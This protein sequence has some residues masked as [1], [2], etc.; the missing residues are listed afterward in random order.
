MKLEIIKK[1]DCYKGFLRFTSIA[2]VMDVDRALGLMNAGVICSDMPIIA[3]QF[4]ALN[5]ERIRASWL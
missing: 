2:F 3:L 1:S 4:L 5:R